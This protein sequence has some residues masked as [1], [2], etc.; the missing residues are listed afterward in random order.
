MFGS[1]GK[2]AEGQCRYRL[3][4]HRIHICKATKYTLCILNDGNKIGN[5]LANNEACWAQKFTIAA[6]IIQQALNIAKA[7]PRARD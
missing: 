1:V 3:T 6:H 7:Y 4:V 5:I 2:D